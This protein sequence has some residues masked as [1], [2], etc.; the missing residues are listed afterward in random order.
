MTI[1][2]GIV[3]TT[4][5]TTIDAAESD[6]VFFGSPRGEHD[7]EKHSVDMTDI[8]ALNSPQNQSKFTGSAVIIHEAVEAVLMAHNQRTTF[9]TAH[10]RAREQSGVSLAMNADPNRSARLKGAA[11]VVGLKLYFG[12]DGDRNN[13]LVVATR[14]RNSVPA[15]SRDLPSAA[16]ITAVWSVPK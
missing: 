12:I 5:S 9:E 2:G 7:E 13:W 14:F 6:E 16:K 10:S 11:G 15:G 1:K 8:D 3:S 4:K